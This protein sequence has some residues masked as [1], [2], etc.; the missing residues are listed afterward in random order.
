[1]RAVLFLGL[2]AGTA[3]FAGERALGRDGRRLGVRAPSAPARL[4]LDLCGRGDLVERHLRLVADRP[5][6][7]TPSTPNT[8]S[9]PSA[10]LPP[11]APWRAP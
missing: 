8:P 11:S 3:I 6:P 1:M 5:V 4:V 9:A 7:S 2:A 10:P